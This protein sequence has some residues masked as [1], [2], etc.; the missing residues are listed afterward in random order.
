MSHESVWMSRPR[1]YGKG[2][3]ECR[4]CTHKA[5]LIRKY[6]LNICRQCFREKAADIGF[7]KHR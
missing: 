3:R 5:G 4:V 1:T 2:S 7:V 6:G